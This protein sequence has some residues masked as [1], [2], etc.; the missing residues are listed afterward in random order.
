MLFANKM[1]LFAITMNP[2]RARSGL[3]ILLD[4]I[5]VDTYVHTINSIKE[6]YKY[7]KIFKVDQIYT[8]WIK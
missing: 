8:D 6:Y 5:N 7:V 3:P 1:K 4:K 2:A